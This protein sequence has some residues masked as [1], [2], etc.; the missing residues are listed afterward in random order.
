M[1]SVLVFYFHLRFLIDTILI[2]AIKLGITSNLNEVLPN[3]IL[4]YLLNKIKT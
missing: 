4:I 2:L 3:S 1:K